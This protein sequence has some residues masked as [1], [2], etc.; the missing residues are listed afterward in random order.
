MKALE[1]LYEIEYQKWA[2]INLP[3]TL[4]TIKDKESIEQNFVG[5]ESDLHNSTILRGTTNLIV[6]QKR[7]RETFLSLLKNNVKNLRNWFQRI[8]QRSEKNS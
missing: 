1:R 5:S 6:N 7:K 4:W 2:R 8:F 3:W